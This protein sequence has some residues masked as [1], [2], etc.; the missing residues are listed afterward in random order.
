MFPLFATDDGPPATT[1]EELRLEGIPVPVHLYVEARRYSRISLLRD[2]VNVRLPRRMSA[3]M[4]QQEFS[5]LI[6][7][8]RRRIGRKNMY[9]GEQLAR[10]YTV[11]DN[12]AVNGETWKLHRTDEPGTKSFRSRMDTGS[13]ELLIKGPFSDTG[14]TQAGEAVRKTVTTLLSRHYEPFAAGLVESV[15]DRTFRFGYKQVNLKYMTSRW[16]SCSSKGNINLSLRLLLIPEEVR[17]YVIVHELAHLREMNHSAR[18]WALVA[19]QMPDY[20]TRETWL[21]KHGSDYDF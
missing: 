14:K 7:W 8:A 6:D 10:D 21:K 2:R 12:L 17:D 20:R 16:G 4:R 9:G 15:N 11:L 18:F 3:Q 13:R 1:F 5:A 19:R